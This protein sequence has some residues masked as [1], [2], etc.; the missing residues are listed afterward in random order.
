MANQPARENHVDR[1]ALLRRLDEGLLLPL[2]LLVASAGSGKTV[3]LQQ[4]AESHPSLPLA[5]IDVEPADDDVV[6]FASRVGAALA[7]VSP[8]VERSPTLGPVAGS[9]LTSLTR[10]RATLPE[11]VIVLD[12][13][14]HISKPDLLQDLGEFIAA[15]PANLHVVISTRVDPPIAW[16]RLR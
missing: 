3:L 10:S 5:W 13:L 8:E 12:D 11:T 16:S 9:P 4:W 2:T 7:A 1:P 6:G 14:H 15:L